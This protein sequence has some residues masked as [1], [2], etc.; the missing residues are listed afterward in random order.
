[1]IERIFYN[2]SQIDCLVRESGNSIK[3]EFNPDIIL[4]IGGGGLIPSRI[5]RSILDVPIYVVTISTYDENN[6]P[7]KEP[8]IVQWMDFSLLKNKKILIVDEVDDTRKTLKF[9]IDKLILSEV[10]NP[11]NLGIFV[12]H[13]KKKDKEIS[14]KE[15]EIGYYK[16]GLEVE[17]KWIIYP[18]D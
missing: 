6:N 14:N 17:D 1:M 12:V 10:L 4:A 9:L 11:L 3:N 13:N 7:I 5:L 16:S 2:Y 15:L 18:W 8:R